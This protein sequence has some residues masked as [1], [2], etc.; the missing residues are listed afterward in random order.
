MRQNLSVLFFIVII[1]V[2]QTTCNQNYNQY[3]TLEQKLREANKQQALISDF[4]RQNNHIIGNF[5]KNLSP[6]V[7]GTFVQPMEHYHLSQLNKPVQN[8]Q[9]P[10]IIQ[11]LPKFETPYVSQVDI[12]GDDANVHLDNLTQYRKNQFATNATIINNG[13]GS[14]LSILNINDNQMGD[15]IEDQINRRI[16]MEINKR[17]DKYIILQSNLNKAA[18]VSISTNPALFVQH[19]GYQTYYRIQDMQ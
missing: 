15:E 18:G 7:M 14:K 19:P 1:I 9:N 10:Y 8:H 11:V 3:K 4:L 17:M 16:L 5:R 2:C 6:H 13:I 12:N